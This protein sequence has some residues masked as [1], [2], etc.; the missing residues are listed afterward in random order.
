MIASRQFEAE[1]LRGLSEEPGAWAPLARLLT[2]LEAMYPVYAPC[3]VLDEPSLPAPLQ[4]PAARCREVDCPLRDLARLRASLCRPCQARGEARQLWPL[5]EGGKAVLVLQ[6]HSRRSVQPVL[7]WLPLLA[8]SVQSI[9]RQ[10]A[11]QRLEQ[12]GQD[13][14]LAREL[15]DS[16][17]QHL[18]FLAFQ[19]SRLQSLLQKP[20]Q[21]APVLE[22]LRHG[23]Q[24]VQR[25]VRELIGN[26]RLSLDG[27]GLRQSL[28]DSVDEFARRSTIVFELDNR[29]PDDLLDS[30]QSLQVLQIV[31]ESL[32]NIVR[33]SHARTARID[34]RLQDSALEVR[35][36]D[37]GIGL[38]PSGESGHFGLSIMRERALAI[39]ASLSI[40][41][42][43]PRGV[44]VALRLPRICGHLEEGA[45][46]KRHIAVDR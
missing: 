34:M 29:L 26:A 4:R 18:G 32:A 25:Q 10:R 38:R 31:R 40:E 33:H 1:L 46:G 42:V 15:H 28:Q 7:G 24:S 19:A 8:A 13:T 44:C 6:G 39:G 3:L 36:E 27:R 5:Q 14:L 2:E 9:A 17:A 45:D 43:Q 12:H 23:L 11:R 20:Q 35:V 22:E 16:V 37:D 30:E 41:S 21:A